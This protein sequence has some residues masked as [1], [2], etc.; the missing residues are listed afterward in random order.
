MNVKTTQKKL[1]TKQKIVKV[2]HLSAR[3]TTT[4]NYKLI[5]IR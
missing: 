2:L 4:H 3:Y 5:P 1:N